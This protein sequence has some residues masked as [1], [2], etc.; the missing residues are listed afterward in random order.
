M[1]PAAGQAG[2]LT[3]ARLPSGERGV[4]GSAPRCSTWTNRYVSRERLP[5]CRLISRHIEA[6]K[7]RPCP[8]IFR[9]AGLP[10]LNAPER[11]HRPAERTSARAPAG[12]A[13]PAFRRRHAARFLKR[14]YLKAILGSW[15]PRQ[16]SLSGEELEH[17]CGAI[18]RE[19]EHFCG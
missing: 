17:F 13:R 2:G 15:N 5:A 16:I 18:H 7:V 12:L 3:P 4:W 14:F 9:G 6:G 11:A 8:G 19:M 10:A 1:L